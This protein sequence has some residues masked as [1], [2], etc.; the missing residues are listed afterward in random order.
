MLEMPPLIELLRIGLMISL[1]LPVHPRASRRYVAMRDSEV[2]KMPG[3]LWSERKA[4]IGLYF[5]DGEGE[6]L[7]DIPEEVDGGLGVVVVVDA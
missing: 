2:G 6:I 7:P 1:D 4:V 3:E 5:L